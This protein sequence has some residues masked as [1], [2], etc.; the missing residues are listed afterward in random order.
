MKEK[1]RL[2]SGSDY[3]KDE[4]SVM[5]LIKKLDALDLDV[6]NFHKTIDSLAGLSNGLIERQHFDSAD[7]KRRQVITNL[8]CFHIFVIK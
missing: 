1:Q 7:I 2:L 8:V 3:G 4:D 5:S 6:E